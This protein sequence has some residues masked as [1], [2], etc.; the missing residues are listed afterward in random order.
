MSQQNNSY[1]YGKRNT[2]GRPKNSKNLVST[3]VKDSFALLLENN[4]DQLQDDL[5]QLKPLD[6]L[7]IIVELAGY[8]IPKLKATDLQITEQEAY[9]PIIIDLSG[10]K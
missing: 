7:K 1:F 2:S 8:F 5:D 10:I 3:A 9:K 4:L 6:R